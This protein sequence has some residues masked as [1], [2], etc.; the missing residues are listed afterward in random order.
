MKRFDVALG[1]ETV[2][3]NLLEGEAD[4]DEFFEWFDAQKFI[5]IDTETSGLNIFDRQWHMKLVQFGNSQEAFVVPVEGCSGIIKLAL[6]QVESPL[7]HNAPYDCVALHRARL[8]D[9]DYLLQLAHDTRIMA[10]LIDP[11]GKDEGGTG[12][13]LKE[14]SRKYVAPD[15]PDGE[16]ALKE[17]FKANKWKIADGW[18]N[19]D[20]L[21]ETL[22][23]YA[24]LDVILTSRLK[25]VLAPQVIE[26]GFQTLYNF[27]LDVQR[28][29][30]RMQLKGIRM[31]VAYA[32]SLIPHFNKLEEEGNLEAAKW[33]IENVNSPKQVADALLVLGAHLPEKTPAGAPKVDKA[34]LAALAQGEGPA[35]MA[36]AGV[37]KAKQ[38]SKFRTTFV[39]AALNLRDERNR[40]HPHI[41]ALQARTARMSMSNPNLQQ[42]PSSDATIRDMFIADEGMV[43]FAIDYSQIELRILAA[44]AKEPNMIQAIN[45]G[46]DLH[47]MTAAAVFGEDFTPYQRKLAK[48]IGFGKVYGGG[49]TTLSR[50]TG[51]PVAD[52]KKAVDKYDRRFP[53]VKRYARKLMEEAEYGKLAVTTPSGRELPL[54]R[55]RLYAATN[56]VVQSTARDVIAQALVNIEE[57]GLSD[58]LLL[59]IHDEFI[60]QATPEEVGDVMEKLV[61]IMTTQF[62]PVVLE[63]DAQV[64]G[65]RW[66]NAY[67]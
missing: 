43:L 14:L 34:V 56:Y 27:E 11:R 23:Q 7:F 21:D 42:L 51:A 29:T 4:S 61:A 17:V 8:A 25:E 58:H 32:E 10:H 48:A 37:Q 13:T 55:D 38:A 20:P 66:G 47:D 63:V 50:Q 52:V 39:E 64:I 12:H 3:V 53:K 41:N 15:A 28:S 2:K 59:V 60:G 5:A 65:D 1:S 18:K 16:V 30:A 57:A 46:I 24:G 67:K 19:I 45:D 22:V 62:G 33:G 9:A 49:V 40:V 36:A 26:R 54:D 31:D 35:A 44:L 6:D